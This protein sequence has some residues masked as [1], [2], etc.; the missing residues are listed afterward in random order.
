MYAQRLRWAAFNVMAVRAAAQ[1]CLAAP[2][3]H[4]RQPRR[5]PMP[6]LP[7]VS[8]VSNQHLCQ[9]LFHMDGPPGG[10]R[11]FLSVAG[12]WPLA[13]ALIFNLNHALPLR[14]HLAAGLL[15]LL[16]YAKWLLPQQVRAALGLASRGG[17][18]GWVGGCGWAAGA[19][20]SPAADAALGG[21]LPTP[22]ATADPCR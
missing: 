9:R 12:F 14:H 16:V 10:L 1:A 7:Q 5:L 4:A 18:V 15:Q 6:P 2:A 3:A 20:L 13:G 17:S 19:P 8:F 21:V 22:A 11:A